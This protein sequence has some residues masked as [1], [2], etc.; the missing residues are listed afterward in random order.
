MPCN[1]VCLLSQV[2][3][4]NPVC[5]LSQVMPCN[6]VC[7]LSQV[8]LCNPVCLVGYII[9]SWMFFKSR[10]EYEEV[11]LINFFGD[12]YITYQD[13]VGTGLPFISGYR[14]PQEEIDAFRTFA[15]NKDKDT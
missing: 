10:I 13:Q 3:P 12:D 11:M 6:P 5:L 9:A 1:P 15:D 7:L 2:M 8:M 14:V 4:Y